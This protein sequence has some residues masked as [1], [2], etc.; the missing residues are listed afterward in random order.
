MRGDEGAQMAMMANMMGDAMRLAIKN[1]AGSTA[2]DILADKFKTGEEANAA[3]A[4]AMQQ[5]MMATM[6]GGMGPG[7]AP[8]APA[9][10][11]G[12]N[13]PAGAAPAGEAA[14]SGG[15]KGTK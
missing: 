8:T 9:A 12:A 14:P 1:A 2:K 5:E 15:A 3:F 10:P 7:A 4:R 11:K 6:G 13:A